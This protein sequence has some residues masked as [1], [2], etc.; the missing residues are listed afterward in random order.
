MQNGSISALLKEARLRK[1]LKQ[2]E[3]AAKAGCS[4]ATIHRCEKGTLDVSRSIAEAIAPHLG[5][6]K[7]QLHIR[8]MDDCNA[9]TPQMLRYFPSVAIAH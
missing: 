4:H 5:L 7:L 6:D 1:G 8:A 2:Q 3:L 9:Q